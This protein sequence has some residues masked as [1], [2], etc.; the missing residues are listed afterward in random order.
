MSEYDNLNDFYR[1]NHY[2]P[3][4]YAKFGRVGNSDNGQGFGRVQSTDQTVRLDEGA[5]YTYIGMSYP[6][7]S[8]ASSIWKVLRLTIA[9]DTILFAD[10]NAFYDNKWDD[11]TTL[12]YS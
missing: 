8:T 10:G 2:D 4:Q 9:D 12:T 6:G 1:T 5:T 3:L 7:A 11:R